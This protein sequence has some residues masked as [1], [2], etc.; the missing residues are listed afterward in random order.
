MKKLKEE[1]MWDKIKKF[2]SKTNIE[3]W[4]SLYFLVNIIIIVFTQDMNST[5]VLIH[6]YAY[7]ILVFT[8][9]GIS[10]IRTENEEIKNLIKEKLTKESI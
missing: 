10:T 9:C 2:L 5:N 4:L 1:I 6:F 8:L 7:F 3:S